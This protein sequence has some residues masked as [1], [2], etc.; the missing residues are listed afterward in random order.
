MASAPWPF[1]ARG[2]IAA[3][4]TFMG[5]TGA[6]FFAQPENTKLWKVPDLSLAQQIIFAV[7]TAAALIGLD[8][9]L[10]PG[11]AVLRAWL[12]PHAEIAHGADAAQHALVMVSAT[13]ALAA[14]TLLKYYVEKRNHKAQFAEYSNQNRAFL[15]CCDTIKARLRD[16][17]RRTDDLRDLADTYSAGAPTK[18][19]HDCAKAIRTTMLDLRRLSIELGELALDENETWL[20]AHRERPIEATTGG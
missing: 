7:A 20:Q 6:W 11:L 18:A 16:C 4:L 13:L 1:S 2:S 12:E 3:A 15:R 8:V 19:M 10:A 14:T 17:Q 9:L 5:L